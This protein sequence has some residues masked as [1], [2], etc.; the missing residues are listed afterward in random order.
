MKKKAMAILL[1]ASAGLLAGCA[2]KMHSDT[3]SSRKS[4]VEQKEAT[5]T[6][7]ANPNAAPDQTPAKAGNFTNRT[8]T[9]P[10]VNRKDNMKLAPPDTTVD[11]KK[12]EAW[13]DSQN[14]V[15]PMK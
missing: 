6:P 7:P 9:G 4:D 8:N 11:P 2:Q 14:K 5:A 1:V 15:K 10:E 3:F 12:E 13:K